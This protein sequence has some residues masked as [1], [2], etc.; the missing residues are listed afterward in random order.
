MS[1]P[2]GPSNEDRSF[3]Y[4]VDPSNPD[5]VPL[6]LKDDW[7]GALQN[8]SYDDFKVSIDVY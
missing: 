6:K 1:D 3:V 4:I 8:E 2:W 7:G 5:T